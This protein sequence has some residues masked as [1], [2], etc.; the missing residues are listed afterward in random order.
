MTQLENYRNLLEN[1][2]GQTINFSNNTIENNC[3]GALSYTNDFHVFRD[4]F[5]ERLKRINSHYVNNSPDSI[6]DIIN[7][8]KQIAQVKGYKWS[9]PYSE[10]VTLDYWLQFENIMNIKF[11]DKGDVNNFEDSI[12]K[13]IG[14]QEVDLD[15]SLDLHTKRIYT[16]VKSLIPTHTELVDQI[17]NK[18]KSRTIAQN[19]LIGIDDLFEVDYIRT[20]KDF[21]YELQSGNLI[22]E[23]EKCINE[24]T[25]YYNHKLQSGTDAS[26]R[27]AYTKQGMNTVLSTMR[28]MEPYKL[29]VDYKYKI[30]DYYNKLLIK[31]PSLI[32]FVINPW[33]NQE[34]NTSQ[35]F[36]STFYRSLSRRIFMELTKDTTDMGFIYP[37][38]SGKNLKISDI[39]GLITGIVYINDN[40]IL[41]TGNDINDVYIY[42]NPNATNQV[43][44]RS[45]FDILNW[46]RQ[47]KY[48]FIEDFYYDNY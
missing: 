22:S 30:L 29:A 34:L 36:L 10:L 4:N 2:F 3:I 28:I 26:F 46:S 44:T 42:L 14:Q 37:E 19:Y 18:V 8:A 43:L 25:T 47:I 31:K 12:A 21:I 7:T 1:I 5:I 17:L 45:D 40:S 24:N 16:D 9:G 13:Q 27:I 38:L 6:N 32:T 15:I 11:I 35:D 39:A 23:L 41:K 33:F 20:K 48:P